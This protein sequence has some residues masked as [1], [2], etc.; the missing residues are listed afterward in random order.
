MPMDLSLEIRIE[1]LTESNALLK[2]DDNQNAKATL[3]NTHYAEASVE[4][5]EQS[6]E[7]KG[8]ERQL[9]E[10][11]E[12][13]PRGPKP[14]LTARDALPL[15]DRLATATEASEELEQ[16]KNILIEEKQH[17]IAKCQQYYEEIRLLAVTENSPLTRARNK[18]LRLCLSKCQ[19]LKIFIEDLESGPETAE[20]ALPSTAEME[21]ERLHEEI[22]DKKRNLQRTIEADRQ[23]L[24]GNHG[25]NKKRINRS[26]SRNLVIRSFL[27][28][29]KDR[30]QKR[31]VNIREP[32]PGL[33]EC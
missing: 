32:R 12:E 20:D 4:S 8:E 15:N 10:E 24:Y 5:L 26:I 25:V 16:I 28:H 23:Q 9:D 6:S 2:S 31:S 21:L 1:W 18:K 14:D 17:V 19:D 33:F 13:V 11:V 27:V 3:P 29:L 7:Y 30:I 22:K